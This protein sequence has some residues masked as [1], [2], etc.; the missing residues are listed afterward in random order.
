MISERLLEE[1]VAQMREMNSLY[2][3]EQVCKR[4]LGSEEF[5]EHLVCVRKRRRPVAVVMVVAVVMSRKEG[6]SEGV[7][8]W[9]AT[10]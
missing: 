6:I 4:I 8:K 2:Y 7:L 10:S 1:G 3:V 9:V 5:P